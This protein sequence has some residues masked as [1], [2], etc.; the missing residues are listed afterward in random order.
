MSKISAFTGL[1][2]FLALSATLQANT[3]RTLSTGPLIAP[4]VEPAY[5]N[6]YDVEIRRELSLQDSRWETS[7]SI[8]SL[9]TDYDNLAKSLVLQIPEILRPLEALGLQNVSANLRAR[10]KPAVVVQ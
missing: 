6:S 8:A 2:L 1:A 10:T 3:P 9:E 4:G 5:L 7:R